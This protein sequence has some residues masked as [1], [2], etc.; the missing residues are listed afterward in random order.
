VNV[1][2]FEKNFL[3]SSSLAFLS[4]PPMC[5]RFISLAKQIYLIDVKR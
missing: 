1:V 3:T 4:N 2:K 5:N